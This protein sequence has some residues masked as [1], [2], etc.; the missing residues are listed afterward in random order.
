MAVAEIVPR[1]VITKSTNSGPVI[2]TN[3]FFSSISLVISHRTSNPGAVLANVPAAVPLAPET[4]SA[5]D[6]RRGVAGAV[7]FARGN[8]NLPLIGFAP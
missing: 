6:T 1:S 8:L 4:L 7:V 5:K 3:G 2:S